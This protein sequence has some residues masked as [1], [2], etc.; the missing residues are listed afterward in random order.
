M[1]DPAPTRVIRERVQLLRRLSDQKKQAYY[2]R[3]VGEELQVLVQGSKA[4]DRLQGL[5]RNYIP[6]SLSG[7]GALINSE[8]TL[9]ITSVAR[10]SVQGE[11]VLSSGKRI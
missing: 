9:R 2:R 10:D 4:D 1:S 7:D 11:L 6:V 3:F 8:V 5:S